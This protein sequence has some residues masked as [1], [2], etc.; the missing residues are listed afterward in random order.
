ML[1]LLER[2]SSRAWDCP[3]FRVRVNMSHLSWGM[4]ANTLQALPEPLVSR[5]R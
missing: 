4:T 1:G 5:C 3:Y 2:E